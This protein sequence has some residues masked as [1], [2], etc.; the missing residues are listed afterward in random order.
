[1]CSIQILCLLGEAYMP[2]D[3]TAIHDSEMHNIHNAIYYFKE[4][5]HMIRTLGALPIP[6]QTTKFNILCENDI[7]TFHDNTQVFEPKDYCLVVNILQ[8]L[9]AAHIS[10]RDHQGTITALHDLLELQLH[11]KI[12]NLDKTNPK[13]LIYECQ[14]YYGLA[15]A[16]YRLG[17]CFEAL[18]YADITRKMVDSMTTN[19]RQYCDITSDHQ[20]KLI[21]CETNE[22]LSNA[23]NYLAHLG[24]HSITCWLI[25]MCLIV[26]T[27]IV[28][29]FIVHIVSSFCKSYV[30]INRQI[31]NHP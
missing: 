29:Y 23:R 25:I 9:L 5:L 31:N 17:N 8:D 1:M 18:R 16:N 26:I 28:L 4:S 7:L 3:V 14:L 19:E 22:K 10:T 13:S 6:K 30:N 12:T 20:S 2:Q 27:T 24:N 21:Y 11:F 15:I